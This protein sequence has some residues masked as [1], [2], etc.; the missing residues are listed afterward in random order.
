MQSTEIQC[1]KHLFL[2][3]LLTPLTPWKD[4]LYKV[5][6]TFDERYPYV[7]PKCKFDPPLTHSISLDDG[8]IDNL[9]FGNWHPTITIKQ[10]LLNI[11]ANFLKISNATNQSVSSEVSENIFIKVCYSH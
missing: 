2:F 5:F 3:C 10:V 1:F 8:I 7:P 11:R 9:L 4:D 6:L